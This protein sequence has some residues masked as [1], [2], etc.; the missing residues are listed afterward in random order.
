MSNVVISP[1]MSLPVPVVSVDPGPDW[2]TNINACMSGIDSH[3]HSVGKG[4]QITPS[5]ININAALSMNSNNLTN[6]NSLGMVSLLSALTSLLQSLQVVGVDLYFID[7]VGNAVRITQGGTVT[8]STGTI[9]G[10]P[11]GTASASFAGGTFTF[12][13]ATSTPATMNIGPIVTGA[14]VASS[15]TVTIGAS[16]SQPANYALVWPLA[17]GAASTVVANDGA[18]NLSFSSIGTILTTAGIGASVSANDPN[19]LVTTTSQIVSISLTAGTWIIS[20]GITSGAASASNFFTIA[21]STTSASVA[22][23][24]GL[25]VFT[26]SIIN[27]AFSAVS[28]PGYKVTPVSTTTYYL[29]AGVDASTAVGGSITAVR[30]A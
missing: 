21:V 8:G 15:K 28:V 1:D 11:S 4:V 23:T 2:A 16:A 29:N 6:A 22:G 7:G 25:N 9:T 14:A 26:S 19:V 13:S 3:D 10:L 30:I 12:Q 20:A 24:L 17:Q 27:G 18:G 5:G